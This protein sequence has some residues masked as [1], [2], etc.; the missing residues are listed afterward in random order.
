MY[1]LIF[2]SM[3]FKAKGM[4]AFSI[5]LFVLYSLSGIGILFLVLDMI[6]KIIEGADIDLIFYW[7]LLIFL[8]LVKV[9]SNG[10]ADILKHFSGFE[11]VE[12]IRSS[13]ILKL[14]NFP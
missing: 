14:K 11:I 1:K 7:I 13:I 8:L 12:E 4:L 10:V 2:N 5:L 9:I 3:T 6:S